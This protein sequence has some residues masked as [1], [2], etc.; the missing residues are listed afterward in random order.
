MK[1]IDEMQKELRDYCGTRW[2]TRCPLYDFYCTKVMRGHDK[3][4]TQRAYEQV[5][6]RPVQDQKIIIT[7]DGRVTKARLYYGKELIKECEAKCSAKD[8]F[9]F[10]T[11]AEIAFGRIKGEPKEE[12]TEYHEGQFVIVTGQGIHFFKIGQ[13]VR[14]KTRRG[15]G[16]WEA[17]GP[18]PATP[19]VTIYQVIEDGEFRAITKED[20]DYGN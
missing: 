2:C 8:D 11:G 1:T 18:R 6:G 20:M 9:D 14:L 19:G 12:P 7:T 5:F 15:P 3:D 16:K 10:L 4:Y 17:E 13:I